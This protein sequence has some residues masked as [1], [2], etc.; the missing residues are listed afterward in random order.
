MYGLAW[1]TV[2]ALTRGLFWCLFPELRSNKRNRHQNN[3]PVSPEQFVTRVHALFY[4]S[5]DVRIHKWRQKR[6]SSYIDR[7]S[8][9]LGLRSADDVTIDCWLRHNHPTFLTRASEKWYL[10]SFLYSRRY[11]RLVV[12][13]RVI[14][15]D[16]IGAHRDFSTTCHSAQFHTQVKLQHRCFTLVKLQRSTFAASMQKQLPKL[17]AD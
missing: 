10:T 8:H 3:T 1:R 4:F 17:T 14:I 7:V 2:L 13:E 5:H 11:S 9:L 16:F 6:R 15:Y 12:Y